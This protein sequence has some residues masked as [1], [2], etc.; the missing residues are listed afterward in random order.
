[1]LPTM[2]R[3]LPPLVLAAA[4]TA[5]GVYAEIHRVPDQP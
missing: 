2:N 1:M 4:L 5:L 3:L